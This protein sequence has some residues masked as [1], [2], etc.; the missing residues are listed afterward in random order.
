MRSMHICKILWQIPILKAF[1]PR[2]L[3]I[4]SSL[5]HSITTQNIWL[6][7]STYSRRACHLYQWQSNSPLYSQLS[8]P[9]CQTRPPPHRDLFMPCY[10]YTSMNC[11]IFSPL[12]GLHTGTYRWSQRKCHKLH[13]RQLYSLNHTADCTVPKNKFVVHNVLLHK[14]R[15]HTSTGFVLPLNITYYSKMLR[16]KLSSWSCSICFS[17]IFKSLS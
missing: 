16:Y 8:P 5:M 15:S 2:L 3:N 11:L 10:L 12:S 1:I 7:W 14:R 17:Y 6:F 13:S 4:Y 9:T